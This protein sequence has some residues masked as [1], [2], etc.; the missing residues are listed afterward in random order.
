MSSILVPIDFSDNA[1]VALKYALLIAKELKY[2]VQILHVMDMPNF[3][4]FLSEDVVKNLSKDK[5]IS[6]FK[7]LIEEKILTDLKEVASVSV[8]YII[9]NGNVTQEILDTAKSLNPILVVIGQKG[10]GA[11]IWDEFWIGGTT[12]RIIKKVKQPVLIVPISAHFHPLKHIAFATDFNIDDYDVIESLLKMT[13]AS[14]TKV[15]AVHV[16]HPKEKVNKKALQNL[17]NNFSEYIE[18]KSFSVTLFESTNISEGLNE[19][20][21]KEKVSM[22]AVLRENTNFLDRVI[23]GGDSVAISMNAEI[24]TLIFKEK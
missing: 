22:L 9:K 1:T 12:Q 20:A 7:T 10:N 11:R 19:Y 15:S 21:K 8:E 13:K 5:I 14:N 16:V 6:R 4:R 18:S 2:K 23:N 17:Q 24:P 3:E